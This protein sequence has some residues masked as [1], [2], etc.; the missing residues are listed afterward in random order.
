MAKKKKST[1]YFLSVMGIPF[2]VLIKDKVIHS[3]GDECCGQTLGTERR[4]EVSREECKTEELM[5]STLIHEYCHAILYVTGQHEMLEEKQEE[6]IVV[7]MEH[8]F[9]QHFTMTLEEYE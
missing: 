5:N 4:I 9:S 6:A 1:R 2:E 3:D 7:A 8:A